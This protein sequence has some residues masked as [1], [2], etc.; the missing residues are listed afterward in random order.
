METKKI[1]VACFFGGALCC[2]VALMFAPVYWWLGLI[3]GF[4]GGYISYEFREV[5]QAVPDAL[6]TARK[7]GASAWKNVIAK[8]RA[9]LSEPH[10]FFYP[11]AVVTA[12]F[13]LWG[14]YYVVQFFMNDFSQLGVVGGMFVSILLFGIAILAFVEMTW[15]IIVPFSILAFIGVRM[16]ERC[17]WWPFLLPSSE[18]QTKEEVKKLEEKGLQR[19]PIN[20]SNVLRWTAKG[21]GIT[22]M[23]FVRTLWK[24]LTIGVWKMLCFSG[25]FAWYLFKL[26]HS[27][28]RVLCAI[29]GTL[30]G[31]VSYIWFASAS[32]SF[33]EQALLVVFGGFLG[34]AF[35][36]ANWE[37]ISKRLL[38]LVPINGK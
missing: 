2:I 20:Y 34:V 5:R 3:A 29:D 23:F 11:A 32:M 37:I 13:F 1:A 6:R 17:Y 10:P 21:F 12:P 8:A 36:V 24:Y 16:G 15:M 38:H 28:K 18:A 27:E 19:K 25:R 22:I 30:G 7:G 35:G 26:I 33:A 31:A 14:A 9:W 4:A